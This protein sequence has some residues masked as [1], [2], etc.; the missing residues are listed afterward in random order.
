MGAARQAQINRLARAGAAAALVLAPASSAPPPGRPA[1]PPN[2]RW[3]NVPVPE[4]HVALMTVGGVAH[5]LRP[6]R[7]G[8]RV[9]MR[10]IGWLLIMAGAAIAVWAIREA[11]DV[12]LERP[13]RVIT[14]G[15]YSFSRHPMYVAWTLAF[16]GVGLAVNTAWPVILSAPLAALIHRETRAEEERLEAIFG[17]EYAA[18][19][20]R[21]H[22]YL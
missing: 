13:D 2:W 8:P 3:S 22:R 9:P 4:A 16:V 11:G 21:V 10:R 18:Y 1:T 5:A 15:P 12:D 17:T 14:S 6:L 7:L 20:A 19:Q